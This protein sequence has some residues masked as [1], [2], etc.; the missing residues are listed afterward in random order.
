MRCSASAAH[1][2]LHRRGPARVGPR[3]RAC[4]ARLPGV[5]TGPQDTRTQRHRGMRLAADARP[6]ELSRAEA[7]GEL[8]G[9]PLDECP[10]AYLEELRHAARHN[11]EVLA[12]LRLVPRER[13]AG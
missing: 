2:A 12:A 5:D 3:S 11:G 6:Q 1:R 10:A 8:S 4:D 9:D 7:V 13:A